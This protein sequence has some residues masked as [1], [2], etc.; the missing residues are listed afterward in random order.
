MIRWAGCVWLMVPPA[1][2]LAAAGIDYAE[3]RHVGM[4]L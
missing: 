2:G 3:S 1:G 4:R